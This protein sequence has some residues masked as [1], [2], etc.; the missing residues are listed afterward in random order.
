MNSYE[1]GHDADKNTT[2]GVSPWDTLGDEVPFDSSK[3]AGE[4]VGE[5]QY[6]R[7][8]DQAGREAQEQANNSE[9]R[10][11]GEASET[12]TDEE[13]ANLFKSGDF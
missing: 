8:E 5:A 12:M 13:A 9:D 11:A 10:S 3:G 4:E 2:T 6:A 7:Y 1:K